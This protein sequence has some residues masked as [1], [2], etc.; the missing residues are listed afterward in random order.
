MKVYFCCCKKKK[1]I[2]IGTASI[3]I[4]CKKNE[5]HIYFDI[6]YTNESGFYEYEPQ[7]NNKNTKIKVRLVTTSQKIV[8]ILINPNKTVTEL[9]KFYFKIIR[10]QDLF[11]DPS[12]IFLFNAK[13]LFH[14]SNVLIKD[15]IKI[16]NFDDEYRII[17]DDLYDKIGSFNSETSSE[18]SSYETQT[19]SQN[20]SSFVYNNSK[21]LTSN[22]INNNNYYNLNA[23]NYY[24]DNKN[25]IENEV[26]NMYIYE[27]EPQVKRENG[28]I[29]ILLVTTG[30]KKLKILIDPNKTMTE[31]IKFYFE[32]I[33]RQ[34]LFG[35]PSIRF[36]FNSFFIPHNSKDLIKKYI[37]NFNDV[38]TI[39]INELEGKIQSQIKSEIPPGAKLFEA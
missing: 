34:E 35:D 6:G 14:N 11:G 30:Q 18:T 5:S 29:K 24:Q 23:I 10:R 9:I 22:D 15:Y 31:L 20:Q 27:Y 37:N 16:L 19:Q 13:L 21:Y 32:V 3:D 2:Y 26:I 17:I 8:K 4:S 25:I 12:I 33:K 7:V 38:N 36:L 1:N 28:K 39:V